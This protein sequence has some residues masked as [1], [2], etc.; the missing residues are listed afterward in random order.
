MN[1]VHITDAAM[2]FLEQRPVVEDFEKI[3]ETAPSWVATVANERLCVKDPAIREPLLK[4]VTKERCA[5]DP[6]IKF[7]FVFSPNG[8]QAFVTWKKGLQNSSAKLFF[9]KV[10]QPFGDHIVRQALGD[11]HV[12]NN[13]HVLQI[14]NWKL[15]CELEKSQDE[16]ELLEIEDIRDE[17]M[18]TKMK[19]IVAI[20]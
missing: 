7:L 1:S 8:T 13:R 15:K 3:D 11:V 5:S 9:K 4:A 10:F 18:R 12:M 16:A 20:I 6:L 2:N 17:K 14:K 19:E